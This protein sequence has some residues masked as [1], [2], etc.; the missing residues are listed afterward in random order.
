[1]IFPIDAKVYYGEDF[2]QGKKGKILFRFSELH[3]QTYLKDHRGRK[4]YMTIFQGLFFVAKFKRRFKGQT[5]ILPDTAQKLFG[6]FGKEIQKLN[7][8]RDDLV[9]VPDQEFGKEFVVY[10]SDPDETKNL[11][12]EQLAK[13]ILDFRNATGHRL[14]MSFIENCV[15]VAIPL[16][17]DL[18]E[19][20][21]YSSM[22]DFETIFDDYRYLSIATGIVDDLDL[23]ADIWLQE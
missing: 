6:K 9:E 8:F 12:T 2:L 20:P 3:T 18:F 15:N 22:L 23:N 19:P 16:N 5:V 14:S 4:A 7:W 1:K 13:R 10:S 21:L 17:L 11:L